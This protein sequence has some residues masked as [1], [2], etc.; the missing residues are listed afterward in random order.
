VTHSYPA[1]ELAD[2]ELIVEGL[3]ALTLTALDE[4]C[5]NHHA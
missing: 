3:H 2:A 5:A 1:A 4:L